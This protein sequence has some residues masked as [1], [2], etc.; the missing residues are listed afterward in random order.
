MEEVIEELDE[1]E[2]HVHGITLCRQ[3]GRKARQIESYA[4]GLNLD[5]DVIALYGVLDSKCKG[6][7]QMIFKQWISR[8]ELVHIPVLTGRLIE[9]KNGILQFMFEESLIVQARQLTELGLPM[10]ASV[11]ESVA[12]MKRTLKMPRLWRYKSCIV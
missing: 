2:N 1:S 9:D 8:F 4:G 3:C 11:K 10:P 7:E 12:G 5:A 6:T